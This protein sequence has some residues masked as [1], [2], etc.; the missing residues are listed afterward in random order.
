M[1]VYKKALQFKTSTWLQ[2]IARALIILSLVPL[3]LAALLKEQLYFK[4]GIAFF[5]TGCSFSLVAFI[6]AIGIKCEV[7]QKR[8]SVV[9]RNADAKY[10]FKPKNE[11]KALLNDFY[12]IEIREGKFRC[13]HCGTE[14]LL[15]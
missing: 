12:P 4:A 11:I 7:C 8:P 10:K 2:V 5:L 6:L 15:R 3:I 14:Y 1:A 13:V 9:I